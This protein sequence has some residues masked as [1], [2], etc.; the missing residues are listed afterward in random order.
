MV[1]VLRLVSPSD[2]LSSCVRAGSL[3]VFFEYVLKQRIDPELQPES[4]VKMDLSHAALTDFPPILFT[5]T[6]MTSLDLSNNDLGSMPYIE[7]CG[8]HTLAELGC[9]GNPRLL[10]PPREVILTPRKPNKPVS[11]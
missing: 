11:L 2:L 7:L 8:I 9:V 1:Q 3:G 4:I 10:C 5:L 6:C